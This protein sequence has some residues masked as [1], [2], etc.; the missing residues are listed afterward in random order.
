[1]PYSSRIKYNTGCKSP[2]ST[3]Y[4]AV[5]FVR[6]RSLRVMSAYRLNASAAIPKRHARSTDGTVICSP[7]LVKVELNPQMVLATKD[8]AMARNTTR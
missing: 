2:S 8:A 1:M 4:L 7:N 5:F 3:M 6:R